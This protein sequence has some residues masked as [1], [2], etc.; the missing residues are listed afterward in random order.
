[1]AVKVISEKPVTSRKHTCVNCGYELEFNNVDLEN[2]RTDYE[3]DPIEIRGKYLTC[4]RNECRC[5]QL[6]DRAKGW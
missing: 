4:P 6:V 2:H 5:R 1:M 3:F